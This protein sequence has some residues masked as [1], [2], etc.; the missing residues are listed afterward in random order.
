MPIS[1][2]TQATLLLTAW[3]S[4]PAKGT[5]A[6]LTPSEWSRFTTWLKAQGVMPEA[7]IT[8]DVDRILA[9]WQDAR[10]SRERI[11]RLLER[12]GALGLV[13]EK[14]ERAGLWIIT[15]SDAEYP[16]RLKQRLK[17]QSPPVL[18]GCGNKKLLDQGGIAIVGSRHATDA[19]LN[20]TRALAQ[21]ITT[22]GYSVISGGARGVDE[23]AMLS[24]LEHD[25]TVIGVLANN[26]LH[27]AINGKYRTAVLKNNLVLISPFNPEAP[28]NVGNAMSRN[29]YI[30]CLADAA[31]VVASGYGTGGT[32]NGAMENLK[33]G[34][35]PLWV[36]FDQDIKSGNA[37]L[38][39][40]GARWLP[41][42][43]TLD[44]C[45]LFA[46]RS[47]PQT[48]FKNQAPQLLGARTFATLPA[49]FYDYFLIRLEE[50]MRDRPMKPDALQNQLDISKPQLNAWLKQAVREGKV[51]K[52][53]RPVRYQWQGS[54]R[55]QGSLFDQEEIA[56]TKHD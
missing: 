35:T 53:S 36:K 29:K 27:T 44:I 42:D 48:S 37:A 31:I 52:L 21:T 2:R 1:L 13:L 55:N 8:N 41:P 3:L 39:R 23:A 43:N 33:Q 40:N 45:E 19:D 32:W 6:P 20:D 25:G 38:V 49:S 50:A 11:L 34:W 14:W 17:A 4:K 7:L 15:L 12:G 46:T 10:V 16:L 18:F 47:K 22:Q 24:A 5:P 28:F 30:Y 9:N 26:L 54:E 51:R 56:T